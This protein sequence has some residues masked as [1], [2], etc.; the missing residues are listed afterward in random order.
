M[1]LYFNAV[2]YR[3]VKSYIHIYSRDHEKVIIDV[4]YTFTGSTA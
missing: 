3:H 2:D 1:N 4:K